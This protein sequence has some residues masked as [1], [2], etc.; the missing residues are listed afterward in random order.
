MSKPVAV[1]TD[2]TAYLPDDQIERY[3]L[4]VVPLMV[5]IDGT[6]GREGV[7]VA[8]GQVAAALN[9]R[10]AK[11][12]TSRP[13]PEQF[14][15]AY[16]RLLGSGAAGVVSVHLSAGLSAT[17]ESAKL[18]ADQ[19][20]PAVTVVDAR[21]VGMGLGFPALAAA[22]AAAAGADLRSVREAALAAVG[23]THTYFYVDTLEFLRRGG[24][25]GAASALLGTALSVKPIL[26]VVDGTIV[27]RDKVRTASRALARLVDVAVEAAGESDVDVAVHHLDAPDRADAVARALADRL[28][29]RI[30]DRYLTE[31]GAVVAAHAG[32]GTVAV[33]VHR[34]P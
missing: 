28:G 1:V 25:V 34:R 33:V 12:S 2:S 21:S 15:A 6:E 4:T 13:S 27:L 19:V 31:I 26:H 22:R 3:G 23:R 29:A 10:R 20:G 5:V 8:P 32:P 9:G 7:D 30:R 14:A 18:A 24:R 11:V 16:R 17:W